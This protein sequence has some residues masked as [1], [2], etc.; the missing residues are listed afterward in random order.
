MGALV[1]ALRKN[2]GMTSLELA[3]QL[4]IGLFVNQPAT[5]PQRQ[6]MKDRPGSALPGLLHIGIEF[7]SNRAIPVIS[8][9]CAN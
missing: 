6:R 8:C 1:A 4:G 3:Q 7:V 2:K 5:D 9:G